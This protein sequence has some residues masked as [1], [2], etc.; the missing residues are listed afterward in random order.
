MLFRSSGSGSGSAPIKLA[1]V[2]VTSDPPGADVFDDLGRKLGTT[3]T[4]IGLTADNTE[5]ELTFRHPTQ[6]ERKKTI[7]ASGDMTVTV[8][9]EPLDP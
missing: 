2:Q 4:E 6:K 7:V 9:L 8:V 5:H 1:R 3:P